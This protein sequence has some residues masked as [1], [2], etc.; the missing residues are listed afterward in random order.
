MYYKNDF[1][2]I[3][4]EPHNFFELT[5]NDIHGDA[6]A[7]STLKGKHKC[8]LI[9]NVACQCGLTSKNYTE[10]VQLHDKYK[11]Q[12]LLIMG[13]PCNQF[14]NQESRPEFEIEK[15]VKENYNADF[16]LFQKVE[17]NGENP[18]PVYKFL[19]TH[20]SLFDPETKTAKQIPWNFSKFLVGRDGHVV[21][22]HSPKIDPVALEPE[23][24]SLLNE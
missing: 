12:G 11:D 6:V 24:V 7:F 22:Y 8:F 18:H 5:A 15:Y 23:I 10:L 14:F 20:S 19:R 17:V 21:A 1:E 4:A 16:L 9:V 3:E 13:F 2:T